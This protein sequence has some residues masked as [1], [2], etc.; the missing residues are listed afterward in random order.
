MMLVGL[1]P[2]SKKTKLNINSFL[3]PLVNLL[4]T[5]V[6]MKVHSMFEPQT[7]KCVLLCAA[8]NLQL[9]RNYVDFLATQLIVVVPN[10]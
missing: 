6:S 4:W 9:V 2:G 8:C 3:Q 1:I 10:V 7:V 5:G